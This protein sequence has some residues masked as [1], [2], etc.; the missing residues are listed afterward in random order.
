LPLIK[1]WRNIF[2]SGFFPYGKDQ[3]RLF[4][5]DKIGTQ[6]NSLDQRSKISLFLEMWKLANGHVGCPQTQV[7]HNPMELEK[8]MVFFKTQLGG[9]T[10]NSGQAFLIWHTF[11]DVTPNYM[12]HGNEE[13]SEISTFALKH[14]IRF[15]EIVYKNIDHRAATLVVEQGRKLMKSNLRGYMRFEDHARYSNLGRKAVYLFDPRGQTSTGIKPKYSK[16]IDWNELRGTK[17]NL[18]LTTILNQPFDGC[19]RIHPTT[20]E[21]IKIPANTLLLDNLSTTKIADIQMLEVC[22]KQTSTTEENKTINAYLHNYLSGKK[23]MSIL[24]RIPDF[25]FK[26]TPQQTKLVSDTADSLTIG[27]SGT[28]KTTCSVLR[29]CATEL[30]YKYYHHK[31]A[32]ETLSSENI[33]TSCGFRSIFMTV[34]SN[35]SQDVKLFYEKLIFQIKDKFTQKEKSLKADEHQKVIEI[36]DDDESEPNPME[37]SQKNQKEAEDFENFGESN[38]DLEFGDE[39]LL[40]DNSD[41]PEAKVFTNFRKFSD[42]QFPL[43]TTI[44]EFLYLLDSTLQVPFFWRDVNNEMKQEGTGY[45]GGNDS[46]LRYY[47][48]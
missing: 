30:L 47:T 27:R 29:L 8:F 20:F 25:K 34:S 3:F 22:M 7:I 31:E 48:N 42:D 39:D 17:G 11:V 10:S 41:K 19:I 4:F 13:F 6:V 24:T 18:E 36:P 5:A 43:F 44:R 12:L 16:K 2:T 46:G 33:D 23:L 1:F 45:W 26:L 38:L 15:V 35:L 40:L 21:N 14:S 37:N 9:V 32:G 28:G